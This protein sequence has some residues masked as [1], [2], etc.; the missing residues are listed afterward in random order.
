MKEK[1]LRTTTAKSYNEHF[2]R[3]FLYNISSKGGKYFPAK[4]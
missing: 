3:D 4:I 1:M 2:N